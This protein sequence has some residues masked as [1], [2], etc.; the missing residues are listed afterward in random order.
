MQLN[1]FLIKSEA[2]NR[3]RDREILDIQ[4]LAYHSLI[5]SHYDPKKLPTFEKFINKNSN[6]SKNLNA[7]QETKELLLKEYAEHYKG[8]KG[9]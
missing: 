7:S 2:Y 3:K 6:E 8:L 1:E 5:G 9:G 4:F